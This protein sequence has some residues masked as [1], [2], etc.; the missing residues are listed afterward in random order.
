MP[1]LKNPDWRKKIPDVVLDM[2]A[3]LGPRAESGHRPS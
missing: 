3:A 1:G 2:I